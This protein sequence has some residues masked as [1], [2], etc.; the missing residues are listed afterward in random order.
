MLTNCSRKHYGSIVAQLDKTSP[1][2]TTRSSPPLKRALPDACL[3]TLQALTR[4]HLAYSTSYLDKSPIL[5]RYAGW[6]TEL[7]NRFTQMNE[8]DLNSTVGGW[9]LIIS[10]S[11]HSTDTSTRSNCLGIRVTRGCFPTESGFMPD[12]MAE[13]I[14]DLSQSRSIWP[15]SS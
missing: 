8:G 3:P 12:Q 11:P 1:L 5:A 7:R 9:G 10:I 15:L 6:L 14:P 2:S 13:A 4:R